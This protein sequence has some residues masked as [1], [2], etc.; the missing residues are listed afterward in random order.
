MAGSK[1]NYLST[2]LLDHVLGATGPTSVT[3]PS[4]PLSIYLPPATVYV[5]LWTS[6]LDDTATGSTSNEPSGGSYARA[7]VTNNTTNWPNAT[8][9]TTGL[10]QNGTSIAFPT[11]S[12]NW[13]TITQFALCDASTAGNI[14]FWGTLTTSKTIGNGDTASFSAFAL[15]ITED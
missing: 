2:R 9:T 14:L 8:G 6:G 12:A 7:A 11:A 5:G 1:S 4:G 15:S 3:G 10:K 13:G